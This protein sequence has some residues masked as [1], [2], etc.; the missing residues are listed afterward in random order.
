VRLIQST[1]GQVLSGS[2]AQVVVLIALVVLGAW[3]AT[4]EFAELNVTL[5]MATILSAV[6]TL[7]LERL[8][9]R[10]GRKDLPA[11]V[12]S[13]LILIMVLVIVATPF[14]LAF[15]SGVAAL[16]MIVAI[17]LNQVSTYYLAATGRLRR[18]QFA[19]Y[20][21]AI[22]TI[23]VLLAVVW[24]QSGQLELVFTLPWFVS[25]LAGVDRQLVTALQ[26]T[27]AKTLLRRLRPALKFSMLTLLSVN[28]FTLARE[29]PVLVSAQLGLAEITSVVGLIMRLVGQPLAFVAKSAALVV[30]QELSVKGTSG[31]GFLLIGSILPAGLV[32]I[33]AFQILAI[34]LP[35]L[36][37]FVEIQAY[38]PLLAPYLLLS[39]VIGGFGPLIVSLRLQRRELA[40]NGTFLILVLAMSVATIH[41]QLAFEYQLGLASAF[42]AVLSLLVLYPLTRRVAQRSPQM[43]IAGRAKEQVREGQG[44]K[45]TLLYICNNDG[46]DARVKKQV[47]TLA[48]TH[49][50]VFVGVSRTGKLDEALKHNAFSVAVVR[51]ATRSIS[52]IA[53]FACIAAL[54]LVKHPNASIHIVNE[55]NMALLLPFLAGRRVVLDIFDSIFLRMSL[56][57]EKCGLLKWMIYSR[58]KHL[59]VTDEDRRGL[60]PQR[61]QSRATVVPNVPLAAKLPEKRYSDEEKLTIFYVGALSQDRGSL[62]AKQ[63]AEA[64]ARIRVVAAGWVYDEFTRK[65]IDA[66][67]FEYIGVLDQSDV[68]ARISK[69]ADYILAVYPADSTN[70]IYASPNKFYDALHTRTPV[71][72]SHNVRVATKVV[73]WNIGTTIP[74]DYQKHLREFLASLFDMRGNFTFAEELAREHSWQKYER[75]LQGLHLQK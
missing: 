44:A 42:Y 6:A 9:A 63:L 25:S 73:E 8:Y 29:V 64:D 43:Q 4:P 55:Q 57:N 66:G 72:I 7:Q 1:I 68:N 32:Y 10:Y 24:R 74:P 53:R 21:Q 49:N 60:L 26:R 45:P 3:A 40:M 59:I 46:S 67:K 38:L 18:L 75:I 48:V 71:L 15:V 23:L 52:T 33:L 19:R 17:C 31:G 39:A 56:P 54:S 34:E 36:S 5:S 41:G 20:I 70:N 16:F 47:R 2:V 62:V 11:F 27:K 51:G 30:T 14:I 37:E 50:I 35:G 28:S 12:C 69:E 65:L 58:A 61:F 13:H 22:S